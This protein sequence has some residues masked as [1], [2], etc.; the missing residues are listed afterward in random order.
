MTGDIINLDTRRREARIKKSGNILDL[1]A[2]FENRTIHDDVPKIDKQSIAFE[3]HEFR[4]LLEERDKAMSD[5]IIRDYSVPTTLTARPI[6]SFKERSQDPDLISVEK[7]R[8]NDDI[9]YIVRK[10]RQTP[11]F[12]KSFEAALEIIR[13]EFDHLRKK[14]QIH[15]VPTDIEP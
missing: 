11:Q 8:A 3:K 5:G 10:Y 14:K 15:L 4:T 2:K 7:A 6:F 13:D 1:R 12:E 9:L